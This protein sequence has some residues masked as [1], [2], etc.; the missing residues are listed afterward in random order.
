[1]HTDDFDTMQSSGLSEAVAAGRVRTL[2]EMELSK[3]LVQWDPPSMRLPLHNNLASV[4]RF[5]DSSLAYYTGENSGWNGG[6][7]LSLP[8]SLHGNPWMPF[9]DSFFLAL[10]E[11]ISRFFPVK[12]FNLIDFSPD[13]FLDMD[14]I[15]AVMKNSGATFSLESHFPIPLENSVASL[16]IQYQIIHHIWESESRLLALAER[17]SRINLPVHLV[18]H[19]E[20][21][22]SFPLSPP[23]FDERFRIFQSIWFEFGKIGDECS[24]RLFAPVRNFYEKFFFQDPWICRRILELRNFSSLVHLLRQSYNL[25]KFVYLG[26]S[27]R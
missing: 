14:S 25:L 1:M 5:L 24:E 22:G 16:S 6:I 13:P 2:A 8:L 12:H 15:L 11:T 20:G 10:F 18:I 17:V 26:K 9:P 23:V 7:C 3:F 4:S 27:V 19:L 21:G